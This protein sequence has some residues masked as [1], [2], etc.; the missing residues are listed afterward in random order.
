ML[1]QRPI[2]KVPLQP[3]PL[4]LNRPRRL[5]RRLRRPH[6]RPSLRRVQSRLLPS[7]KRKQMHRLPMQPLRRRKPSM[8]P[9]GQMQM[10]TRR[11]RREMRPLR[12]LPL[13][14]KH[15]RL[16]NVQLQRRRLIRL[17]TDLRPARRHMPLQSQR[18]RPKLRPTKTGLLQPR[19]REHPRRYSM[20]LL[21]PFVSMRVLQGLLCLQ[22]YL[23]DKRGFC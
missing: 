18:R 14:A 3:N 6:L 7:R 10:P 2:Q 5:L 12:A 1:L 20:L 11:S 21:R 19:A 23:K 4:R 16:Q 8:R 13:R 15:S 22:S 17:A 9:Y